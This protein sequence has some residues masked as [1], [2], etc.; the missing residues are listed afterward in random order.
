MNLSL[1]TNVF[2]ALIRGRD[3]T[4]RKAFQAALTGGESLH[5][6]LIV[7]DELLYGAEVHAHPITQRES[8]RLVLAQ[9]AI[10]PFDAGDMAAAARMR[11]QLRRRGTPIGAYDTLIAGQALARGWTVVTANA[12]QFAMV[13]GLKLID[14][15]AQSAI[16]GQPDKDI[17]NDPL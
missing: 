16:G 3:P 8:V 15:T 13:G 2:I 9:V 12:C 1:D 4:V 17:A 10:A 7:L 6:S 11:A 14:W 5:A